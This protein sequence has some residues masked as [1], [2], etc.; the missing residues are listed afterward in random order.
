MKNQN[1]ITLVAL[2]ITI[3]VLLILAGVS[4]SLVL[5]QNGVLT[6]ASNAVSANQLAKIREDI[7]LGLAS[8]VTEA[9]TA[10]SQSGATVNV[11]AEV[12]ATNLDANCNLVEN[13]TLKTGGTGTEGTTEG[14]LIYTC[15]D[16]S[17]ATVTYTVTIT[18]TATS[19]SV[20]NIVQ[21]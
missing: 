2:V 14:T 3:I 13:F 16:V 15:E 12:T 21:N 11:V 4:I 1:G 6:Q 8:C 17:D 5:G 20:T 19:A 18:T 7:D 10:M 9:Y